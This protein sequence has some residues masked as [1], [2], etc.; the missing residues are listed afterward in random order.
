MGNRKLLRPYLTELSVFLLI[1]ALAAVCLLATRAIS[2]K[3][4]VLTVLLLI[5]VVLWL[6]Q[7]VFT[8]VVFSCR[9]LLD[10][11]AKSFE[12]ADARYVEQFVFRSSSFLD[13]TGSRAE[14]Y[15]TKETL[16]YKIVAAEQDRV[17]IFT[18]SKYF[19]LE[20]G[21]TYRF[22]FGKRSGAI[23]DISSVA[24]G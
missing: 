24:D 7:Y 15:R 11:A 3:W 16:F 18:S 23:T 10:C 17:L 22:V 13:K 6:A 2:V 14:N 1:A 12:T 8:F 19:S 4:S 20:P 9:V 5:L 21:K